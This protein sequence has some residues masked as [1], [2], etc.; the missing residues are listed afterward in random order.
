MPAME[1]EYGAKVVDK[2]NKLLGIVDYLISDT[3]SGEIR[4]FMVYRKASQKDLVL[5]PADV[6]QAEKDT[7]RLNVTEEELESR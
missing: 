3:W 2:N 5:S 4:K 1:L 7:V 6:A